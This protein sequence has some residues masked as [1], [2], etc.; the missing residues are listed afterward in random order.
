MRNFFL[1]ITMIGFLNSYSQTDCFNPGIALILLASDYASN[2]STLKFYGYIKKNSSYN[3]ENKSYYD[4]YFVEDKCGF[5]RSDILLRY[6]DSTYV[7]L[8]FIVHSK[9]D[10]SSKFIKMM[11]DP[12]KYVITGHYYDNRLNKVFDRYSSQMVSYSI[13]INSEFD[14]KYQNYVTYII[15]DTRNKKE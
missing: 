3:K 9:D 10:Y 8:L 5:L 14:E 4:E 2:A 1:I 13:D 7:D 11:S 15:A 6:K 12:F